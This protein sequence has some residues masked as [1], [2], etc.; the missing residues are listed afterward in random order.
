MLSM[1]PPRSCNGG[2]EEGG[3]GGAGEQQ[4]S[5]LV[6]K[7]AMEFPQ[8]LTSRLYNF[9][10]RGKHDTV[11][12]ST[13]SKIPVKITGTNLFYSRQQHFELTLHDSQNYK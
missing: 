2:G 13:G 10:R 9:R 3:G 6:A 12:R 1:L 4:A 7:Q 8:V 5:C 11:Q